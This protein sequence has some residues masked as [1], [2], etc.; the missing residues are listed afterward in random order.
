MLIFAFYSPIFWRMENDK[1]KLA[2]LIAASLIAAVRTAREPI[3]HS[4]KVV[5][6]V[7]ESITLARMILDRIERGQK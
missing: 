7:S 1:S 6:A 3:K 5:G 2:L 4:P